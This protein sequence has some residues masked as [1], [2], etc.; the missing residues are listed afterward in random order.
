ME[1]QVGCLLQHIGNLVRCL[2]KVKGFR[3]S[4]TLQI[5]LDATAMSVKLASHVAPDLTL[6]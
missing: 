2:L 6:P 5:Y 1:E 4:I 3:G